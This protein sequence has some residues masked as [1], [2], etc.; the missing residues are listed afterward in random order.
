MRA[1][2]FPSADIIEQL[3]HS[4]HADNV[5]VGWWTNIKTGE[6]LRFIT[7]GPVRNMGELL[8][9]CV[10]ELSE[11]AEGVEDDLFDDKL[12]H[13][14]MFDVELGDT[15]IRD[16]DL[17][18]ARAG[19]DNTPLGA[20]WD[21]LQVKNVVHREMLKQRTTKEYLLRIV[22]WFSAAMEAD[23]KNKAEQVK[24]TEEISHQVSGV[25]LNL[26]YALRAV[27]WLAAVAGDG[28]GGHL[29]L[30]E[31]ITEKRAFNATRADHQKA[32]RLE[33]GGKSY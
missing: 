27:F 30:L 7:E 22:G 29:D 25:T 5:K 8:M 12:P 19:V 32:N 20:L 28:K 24:F 2:A 15:A 10:S 33:A 14:R 21:S 17:L 4:C 18:G 3:S 11:A 13:R 16:F 1:T 9:L 26:M 23:R 31:I 6:D